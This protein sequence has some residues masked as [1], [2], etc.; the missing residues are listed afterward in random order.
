MES[1]NSQEQTRV[2]VSVEI[3]AQHHPLTYCL[4]VAAGSH[5]QATRKGSVLHP[6]A[7]N[8]PAAVCSL[9]QLVCGQRVVAQVCAGPIAEPM[10]PNC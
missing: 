7:G 9:T 10:T 3:V 4:L 8:S 1:S 2:A 5:P 6:L